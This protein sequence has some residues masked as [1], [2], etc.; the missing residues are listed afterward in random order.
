[1]VQPP[2]WIFFA[3]FRPAPDEVSRPVRPDAATLSPASGAWWLAPLMSLFIHA[4]AAQ[5]MVVPMLSDTCPG[6]ASR[7]SC[8]ALELGP[9]QGVITAEIKIIK[10]AV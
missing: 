3:R 6:L 8:L 2:G 7:R 10:T 5:F 9:L 4:G 1:M